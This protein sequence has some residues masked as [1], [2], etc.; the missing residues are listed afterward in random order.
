MK[1]TIPI[2]VAAVAGALLSIP[3]ANATMYG[4]RTD[5]ETAVGAGNFTDVNETPW[6]T[7]YSLFAAGTPINLPSTTT[8]TFGVN[9]YGAQVPGDWFTWSGGN[10][11]RVLYSGEGVGTVSGTF[12]APVSSFGLEMEPSNFGQFTM[13]LASGQTLTQIVEGDSGAKFFGWANEAVVGFTMSIDAA[14]AVDGFAFGRMVEGAGAPPPGVP[15]TG[16]LVWLSGLL[17]A[18]LVGLKRRLGQA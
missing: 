12:S 17:W 18:G 1:Q 7:G 8:L 16:S 9:L 11:P 2:A 4:L 3:S 5:W 13:Y 14:G 6:G 10:T 15:D